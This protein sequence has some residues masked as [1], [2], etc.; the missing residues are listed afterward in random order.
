[1]S[2]WRTRRRGPVDQGVAGLPGAH[3]T[4]ESVH[5]GHQL[6]TARIAAGL[7]QADVAKLSGITTPKIS[8]YE[9]GVHEPSVGR[10]MRIARAIGLTELQVVD[11]MRLADDMRSAAAILEKLSLRYGYMTPAAARW[12]AQS[13]RHEANHV[14]SEDTE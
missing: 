10:A 8:A 13:L 1:M 3:V 4:D 11:R 2:D 7:T 6:R 5:V 12:D 9:R 14:E